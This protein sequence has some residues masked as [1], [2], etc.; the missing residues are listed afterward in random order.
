MYKLLDVNAN[1]PGMNYTIT[2]KRADQGLVDGAYI[3]ASYGVTED[4][5]AAKHVEGFREI[6]EK[7]VG[8]YHYYKTNVT[9]QAQAD[10]FSRIVDRLGFQF[11]H[12]LDLEQ[13]YN[14]PGKTYQ[15]DVLNWLVTIGQR[16]GHMPI[17]YSGPSWIQTW[18]KLPEFAVFDLWIANYRVSWPYVPLPFTPDWLIWQYGQANGPYYGTDPVASKVI[19]VNVAQRLPV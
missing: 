15:A 8:H 18:L 5:Q 14:T 16:Y 19:D 6:V 4:T 7:P 11:R 12:S 13:Y 3:R 10:A 2:R 17:I 9:W 1:Q